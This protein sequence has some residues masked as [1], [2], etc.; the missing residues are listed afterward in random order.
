VVPKSVLHP[1][2]DSST[3][4]ATLETAT[5]RPGPHKD[6]P[7]VPTFLVARN[8]LSDIFRLLFRLR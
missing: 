6:R 7:L 1:A 3:Q 4:V 5:V 8:P 2:N